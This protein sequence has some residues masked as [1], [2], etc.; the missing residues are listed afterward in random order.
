[1]C[2]TVVHGF[3]VVPVWV[4]QEGSV[5]ARVIGTFR[6]PAIVAT[7]GGQTGFIKSFHH[8]PIRG[9]KRQIDMC[10]GCLLIAIDI[11]LI[12]DEVIVVFDETSVGPETTYPRHD[13]PGNQFRLYAEAKGID[14]VFVNG[15]EI[16]RG[17][18]HTGKLPGTVL[19]SGKDTRTVAMNAMQEHRAPTPALEPAE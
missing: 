15:V 2:G 6:R 7:A 5:V 4:E 13:V 19:R 3:D 10:R 1:M 9:L 11:H 18:E 14:H 8:F 16:V 12:E 17:G